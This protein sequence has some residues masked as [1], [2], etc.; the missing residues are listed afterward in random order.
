[1]TARIRP[2]EISYDLLPF[3]F[4]RLPEISDAVLV[5]SEV[6]E[7]SILN[8]AQFRGLAKLQPLE[9]EVA[10]SLESKQI[11][12][13]GDPALAVRLLATKLRTRKSFLKGGPALHIFVVTLACD[14]S[15]TYCQVSRRIGQAGMPAEVAAAAVDRMFES[16]SRDLTVE[17]QGGEPLLAFERIRQIVELIE[18]RNLGDA[19]RIRYTITSTLH[20]LTPESLEFFRRHAFHIST[21][22]DGPS[23]IHDRNR[24]LP[25]RD[26]LARTLHGLSQARN[27]L[28]HESVSALTTLTKTSLAEP[29][30]IVDEYVRLGFRSIFLRPLSPFGF[31][32]R[33]SARM[34]Y[35]ANAFLTFYRRA[36]HRILELNSTGKRIEEVYAS[37]LLRAIFTHYPTGYVDL[38]SPVG[39]GLGTIVYNYDGHVYASDEGRMLAEMGDQSLRMGSVHQTYH[40]LMDSQAMNILAASGLAESLPGCADCAFVPYCGPDPARTLAEVGDPVGHRTFSD[41]CRRH[42]GLFDFLFGLIRQADPSTM[43]TL[44]RW[45]HGNDSISEPGRA[46]CL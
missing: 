9:A 12:S 28:G 43:A 14:H 35:D 3:R 32:A 37:L 5:T 17:F 6:G 8:E 1:M 25:S 24:P 46:Q 4:R 15:C 7:F 23:Q 42:L 10:D 2:L 21:S 22:L 36:F 33:S 38:R 26:S 41:H 16:P 40:D 19:R 11:I 18:A 45:V 27:A 34:S 20:H 39:A 29:E 13:R 31:A 44:M 30:A